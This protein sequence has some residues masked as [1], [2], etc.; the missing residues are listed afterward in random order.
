MMV[1]LAALWRSLG[2]EPGAVIGHSQGEVAAACVAGALSLEDAARIIALRSL[3]IRKL[4]GRGAM[5]A[6]ELSPEELAP[7]LHTWGERL[8]IAAFNSPRSVLVSGEP[9]ALD[10]LL[11]ALSAAQHFARRVKVSY[12]S[13]CAQVDAVRE[14]LLEILA[15]IEPR[16]AKLPI[17][18]T[19]INEKLSGPELTADYWYRNLRQPVQFASVVEKLSSEGYQYFVE[20]SPHPVLPVALQSSLGGA[21]AAVVGSLRREAGGLSRPLLSLGELYVRG[22]SLDWKKVL[23][24][25]QRV[26]L[27]TYPF[28]RQR[29]WLEA[30]EVKLRRKHSQQG[31]PLLGEPLVLSTQP[32]TRVW[33]TLFSL[34]ALPWLSD[35]QVQGNVVLPAAGYLEM[36]LSAGT[37]VLG[38]TPFEVCDVEL[39]Q[40]MVIG[41][42]ESLRVQLLATEEQPGQVR[43][44][45]AS[46]AL[47]K[48][49]EPW[50][51]HARAAVKKLERATEPASLDVQS[52][53]EGLGT[54]PIEKF[55]TNLTQVGLEYGP[56]FQGLKEAWGGKGQALGRIDT[57]P[58]AGGTTSYQIHPATLDACFHVMIV[59]LSDIE[60]NPW[61][62]VKIASLLLYRRPVAGKIWCHARLILDGQL[63]ENRRNAD[64]IITDETG[65]VVAEVTGFEIQ[66][67]A[68][69]PGRREEDD[70]FL[71][72]DWE[73]AAVPAP[74]LN[75]GRWLLLGEG[76]G[77]GAPLREALE[78]AGH[79]VVHA[80]AGI[81]NAAAGVGVVLRDSEVAG[82][83]ELLATAFSGAAPTAIVHLRS[84]EGEREAVSLEAALARG[85]DSVLHTIQAV[86][87]MT[88]RDIPRLWLLT[89]GAQPVGSAAVDP[90][91]APLLG[92][93]RT[94][95]SEQ[96]DLRCARGDL[97]PSRPK[98][99]VQSL[100]AEL[101]ADD[102]E[103]EVA[104]RNGERRVARLARSLPDAG[105]FARVE[106]AGVK[107]HR[108]GSYVVTGGLGGLGLSVAGWLAEQG[109]GH[110]VLLGRSGIKTEA[111]KEAVAVLQSHGA[112][113]AVAEVDIADHA[114]LSTVL[115]A[116]PADRPLRGVVHAAGL[117]DDGLLAQQTP[118]RFR[119]VMAPKIPGAWNL[120]SL[121]LKNNLDFFI[122]YSSAAGLFGS[123]GQ[124]SY[125]AANTFLDA[126]AHYRHTQGLPALSIDWGAFSEVGLAAAQAN[127]GTR[128]E[129]RGTRSLSPA[130]GLG[131]LSRVLE[132]GAIQIGVVPLDI[133]QWVEFFPSVAS[134]RLL[135]RLV[136]EQSTVRASGD[137][138]LLTRLASAGPEARLSLLEG[139]LRQQVS[140]VLRVPLDK[141]DS[142]APLTG[143]GMD[144]LMGLELRNR[145]EAA[146][147]ISLPATT[148]WTYPTITKLSLYLAGP[149]ILA[150][151]GDAPML[152]TP[153]E[154]EV[155]DKD[156][157]EADKEGLLALLEAEL[158]LAD[159]E[160]K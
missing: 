69:R 45:I 118:A 47:Y 157:D 152:Q 20:V 101:L 77:L 30:T 137:Q 94:I 86:A 64:L 15:G 150:S 1:S 40:A 155:S 95:S 92:L 117:L 126:L 130:Q 34:E 87:A 2:V 3:A 41:P 160:V 52:L 113:V 13:H 100:L 136:T 93:G 8:S 57:P 73:P 145:I 107:V 29:F 32:G 66:R 75:A 97:D 96:A 71:A 48:D 76:G 21:P 7:Y 80:V 116:L 131:V 44:Q 59:A 78:G 119:K 127:R 51:I 88:W 138:D 26:P 33:E 65:A 43:L 159:E 27:P 124:G 82:V 31:H 19:V 23:P 146:L 147:G 37:Q 58:L 105:P 89:R 60:L 153:G 61:L 156:I 63:P 79:T 134:S 74:K 25:G 67:L 120:H 17:Y 158:N 35:H 114:A 99:E 154:V 68:A 129:G 10:G 139:S 39:S 62:P 36:V 22:L 98:D 151:S 132:G 14:E 110:L 70:W 55:Y 54:T 18:S 121:T 111:Q 83:Q 140:S 142:S 4:E 91:Q 49:K 50:V 109:A 135:S 112:T 81:S 144:S 16:Q 122:L 148:L 143:L 24:Q 9:E 42:N 28:M 72:I 108:D 84:L 128:L 38:D 11:A 6:V 53:R 149:G 141:L 102:L 115:G 133:R 103:D 5:A 123:P 106:P 90:A 125:A 46:Q 104:F 85:C 56:S 12:A